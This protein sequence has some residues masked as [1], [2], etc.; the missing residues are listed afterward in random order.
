MGLCFMGH[1]LDSRTN[2]IVTIDFTLLQPSHTGYEAA[3]TVAQVLVSEWFYKLG[4]PSCLHSDQGRSF[5]SSLIHQLC[6]LYGVAVPVSPRTILLV[7]VSEN[8]LIGLSITSFVRFLPPR[9]GTSLPQ[10]LFC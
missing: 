8:S 9:N 2:E 6:L 1:L 7:M 10:V 4:I 3:P 5:E